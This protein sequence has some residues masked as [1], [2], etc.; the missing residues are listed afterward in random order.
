MPLL[1]KRPQNIIALQNRTLTVSNQD[2]DTGCPF[3]WWWY[4]GPT[5]VT[6]TAG[7]VSL[8]EWDL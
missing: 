3:L 7:S 6:D 1:K 5:E 8:W 4:L 2:S